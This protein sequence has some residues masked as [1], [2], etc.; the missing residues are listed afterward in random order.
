MKNMM[1][2]ENLKK[3]LRSVVAAWREKKP[4]S[5]NGATNGQEFF[6]EL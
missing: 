1:I 5:R 2:D 6:L 3:T 4:A